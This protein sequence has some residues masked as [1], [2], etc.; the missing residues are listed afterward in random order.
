NLVGVHAAARTGVHVEASGV[1]SRRVIVRAAGAIDLVTLGGH[2][3]RAERV[4]GLKELRLDARA[5]HALINLRLAFKVA[6]S[7]VGYKSVGV[8]ARPAEL[9]DDIA[10]GVSLDGRVVLKG[11]IQALLQ[12]RVS[13]LIDFRGAAFRAR[14]GEGDRAILAHEGADG[15]AAVDADVGVV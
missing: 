7:N 3:L 5:A 15:L 11:L 2:P 12:K 1:I 14:H 8:D 6:I 9:I 13:P 10:V 4:A